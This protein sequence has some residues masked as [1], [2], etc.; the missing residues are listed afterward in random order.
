MT[1][2]LFLI[3][4]IFT[5]A[6]SSFGQHNFGLRANLGISYLT[7]RIASL[8]PQQEQKFY[9][10]PSGQI[11]IYYSYQIAEKFNIATDLL[12]IPIYGR[13]RIKTV[14]NS[15][16]GNSNGYQS[17]AYFYRQIYN[18]GF[19]IYFG[20]NYKKININIGF[21]TH[22]VLTSGG[23]QKGSNTINGNTQKNESKM[24]KL[25]INKIDYGPRVGIVYEKSDKLSFNANYYFGLT[26]LLENSIV[27][28]FWVWKVQLLT[29]GINYKLLGHKKEVKATE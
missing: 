14:N 17:E 24:E 8:I 19:P 28:S 27:N 1:R 21:Q 20:Y 16:I 6:L 4:T 9:P 29:F 2:N 26:N 22:Y 15:V 13:D 7:T 10:M 11:G 3:L 5:S 18:L 12:F 23:K 25:G